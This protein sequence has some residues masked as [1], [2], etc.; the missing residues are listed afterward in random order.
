[1]SSG[2]RTLRLLA[3]LQSRRH[4]AGSDLAGRLGISL[5]TL[6]RDVE[7]LRDLGY[8]VQA[9]PGAAGG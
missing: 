9:A 2:E 6:R 4:W 7:R 3:L 5:R 1:M 8:P